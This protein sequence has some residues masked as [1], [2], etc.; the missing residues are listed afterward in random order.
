MRRFPKILKPCAGLLLGIAI[1]CGSTALAREL[2]SRE[3]R[4]ALAN[5]LGRPPEGLRIKDVSPGLAGGDATVTAQMDVTF[6]MRRDS[7]GDWQVASVRLANGEWEDVE[8]IQR[9]ID[10]QKADR[11]RVDLTDLASGVEAFRR[12]RGFLP[13]AKSVAQLV[14]Q[15]TPRFQPRVIRLDPWNRPYSY[16]VTGDRCRLSS[17]GPDGLPNTADDLATAVG[18]PR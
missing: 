16:E 14:D 5:L 12:D 6:Q 7:K 1:G 9:A 15:I 13:V 8:M 2:G 11:A 18:A 4:E 3:A 17:S 10:S